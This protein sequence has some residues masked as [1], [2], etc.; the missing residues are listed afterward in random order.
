M[1]L[2][3]VVLTNSMP[4]PSFSPAFSRLRQGNDYNIHCAGVFRTST[5]APNGNG[6]VM[7]GTLL[8]LEVNPKIKKYRLTVRAVV[9]TVAQA[10][11]HLLVNQLGPQ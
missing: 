3:E 1:L 8:K 6:N 5:P 4:P 11:T 10:M 9:Q 2:L 7:V